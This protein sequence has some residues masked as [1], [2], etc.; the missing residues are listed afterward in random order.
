M[1]IR[2]GNAALLIAL[3][4]NSAVEDTA[5]VVACSYFFRS[6]G[7]SLS[8]GISSAILQQTLRGQLSFRLSDGNQ[9]RQIEEQVRESLDYIKEL[10]PHVAAEVR[11]SYQLAIVWATI[12]SVV[13]AFVAFL[14]SFLIQE[15]R[16]QK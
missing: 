11:M 15:K 2:I 3:L 8:V 10:S 13:F 14:V 6:L 9:A 1:L 4:A 5:V 7:G 12:P 16:L